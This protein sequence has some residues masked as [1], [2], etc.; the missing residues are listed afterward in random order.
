LFIFTLFSFSSFIL[1]LPCPDRSSHVSLLLFGG[2]LLFL[3]AQYDALEH[4]MDAL[5]QFNSLHGVTGQPHH[6][7]QCDR[8][9][10]LWALGE[11]RHAE[12]EALEVG[13]AFGL[14]VRLSVVCL[15][16]CLLLT[17][18]LLMTVIE[19]YLSFHF[20]SFYLFFP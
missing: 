10:L 2:Q 19:I 5:R 20:I 16:A 1:F 18:L 9:A 6:Q 11:E 7:A 8:V 15:F 4:Y 12:A 3:D 17:I 14:S 13:I